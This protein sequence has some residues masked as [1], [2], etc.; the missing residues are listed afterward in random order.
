[1]NMCSFMEIVYRRT[2][3]TEQLI[4]GSFPFVDFWSEPPMCLLLV[5]YVIQRLGSEGDFA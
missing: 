3:Y 1:M 5:S 4:F 2:L